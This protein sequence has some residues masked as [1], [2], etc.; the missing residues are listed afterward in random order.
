MS[1]PTSGSPAVLEDEESA[2]GS[3]M[4]LIV[5]V[6]S[7]GEHSVDVDPALTVEAVKEVVATASGV[8]ANQ[9]VSSVRDPLVLPSVL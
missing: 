3:S 6:A 8:P 1:S 9:Q 4:K 2:R 5:K 7:G